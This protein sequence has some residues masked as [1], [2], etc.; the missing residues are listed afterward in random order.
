MEKDKSRITAVNDGLRR[1]YL[2]ESESWESLKAIGEEA[3]RYIRELQQGEPMINMLSYYDKGWQVLLFPRHKHR[4]WQYFEEGEQNILLSPAS[5]DM[6]GALI[7]PLEKDFEKITREDIMNIFSQ[8]SFTHD[9]F[10]A[11]NRFIESRKNMS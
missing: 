5:V 4:P 6:G 8:V 3:F 11:M 2:L 1:F 9:H 7:T 10:V